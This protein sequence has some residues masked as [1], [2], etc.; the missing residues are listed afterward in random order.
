[1]VMLFMNEHVRSQLLQH[2]EVVTFRRRRHREGG[3]WATDRRCGK[4]ICSIE[5]E[6]LCEV[7]KVEDLAPYVE[8]S[9]FP[10]LWDWVAAIRKFIDEDKFR[11]YLYHVKK[12]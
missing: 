5:V 2:G 12:N 1:M 9:G 6:F 7:N 8:K 11:G 4:K 3:D 10:H